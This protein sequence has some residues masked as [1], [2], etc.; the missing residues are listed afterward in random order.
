MLRDRAGEGL[1]WNY[2]Y[3]LL[4]RKYDNYIHGLYV[5]NELGDISG[6]SHPLLCQ[7]LHVQSLCTAH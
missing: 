3:L 1:S 6:P 4:P 7:L 5:S 2:L